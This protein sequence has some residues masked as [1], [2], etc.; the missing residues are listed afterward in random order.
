MSRDFR[1]DT[2]DYA[3]RIEKNPSIMNRRYAMKRADK[4]YACFAYY[5]VV[6]QIFQENFKDKKIKNKEFETIMW[7]YHRPQGFVTKEFMAYPNGYKQVASEKFIRRLMEWGWLELRRRRCGGSNPSP[8]IY[9]ITSSFNIM[10]RKYYQWAYKEKPIPLNRKT[11]GDLY[12][13]SEFMSFLNYHRL[14]VEAESID[15]A[16]YETKE[17]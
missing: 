12:D 1:W 8:N 5:G 17:R 7:L 11:L 9:A 14:D 6:R 2:K 4:K 3:I 10:F 15:Y 16:V 13:N